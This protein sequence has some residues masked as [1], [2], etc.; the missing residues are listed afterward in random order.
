M[1]RRTL[2]KSFTG[3]V[4]ASALQC[5]GFKAKVDEVKKVYKSTFSHLLEK[6]V[7][8]EGIGF[9]YHKIVYTRTVPTR[10]AIDDII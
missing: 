2:F 3:I 7:L 8:P 6:G 1:T 9:N 5:F 10:S 4:A